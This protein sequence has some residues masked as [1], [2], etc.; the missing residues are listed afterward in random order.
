MCSAPTAGSPP[1]AAPP[2]RGRPAELTATKPEDE[3]TNTRMTILCYARGGRVR[4]ELR[5]GADA[6]A[7]GACAAAAVG[8]IAD[9][10]PSRP[11]RR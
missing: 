11:V 4:R 1:R 7:K 5:P 6:E 8:E 9:L 3:A 10:A 2:T